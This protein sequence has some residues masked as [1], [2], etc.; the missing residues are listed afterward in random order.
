MSVNTLFL[1]PEHLP[2]C[3]PL[4]KERSLY[5]DAERRVAMSAAS[6]LLRAGAARGALIVDGTRPRAFGLTGF[7]NDDFARDYLSNPRPAIGRE[8]LLGVGRNKIGGLLDRN[9]V[10]HGNAGRGL[11]LV[12]LIEGDDLIDRYPHGWERIF[13]KII[14]SFQEVHRGYRLERIIDEVFGPL[15]MEI[16]T[17]SAVY[18]TVR[19]F[20][21]EALPSRAY[22]LSREQAVARRSLLL[23]MFYYD[24]PRVF[25][26]VAEQELLRLALSGDTDQALSAKLDVP[27]SSVKARWTRIL[28]RF[29][30]RLPELSPRL[31]APSGPI[32]GPQ[33]RH[34]V[35]DY[36]RRNPSELTPFERRRSERP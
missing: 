17:R 2:L 16:V 32:R 18:E 23:P 15:A 31:P 29:G 30:A 10:A 24:A 28:A 27:L 35:L 34:I 14:E 36:V 4:W 6:T 33:T 22:T 20:D 19:T 7:V 9:G 5:S 8:L 25:F 3:M 11:T 13:A 21:H 1:A 12:V 26:T